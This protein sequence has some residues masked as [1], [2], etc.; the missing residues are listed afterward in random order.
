MTVKIKNM[1]YISETEELD[2]LEKYLKDNGIKYDRND[3]KG[4]DETMDFHQIVVFDEDNPIWDAVCHM[5]SYGY[6]EGLLEI[7][8]SIVKIEDHVE[9]WLTADD[10]IKRLEA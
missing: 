8:G 9:G 2:K 7:M 1:E 3:R 10:I 6:E 5:G 4:T